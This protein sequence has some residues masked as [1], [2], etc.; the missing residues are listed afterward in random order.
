M[1]RTTSD[2]AGSGVPLLQAAL[3][4]LLIPRILELLVGDPPS[5]TGSEDE[6]PWW[7]ADPEEPSEAGGLVHCHY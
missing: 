7:L 6:L 4:K 2:T 1:F 5:V 3:C